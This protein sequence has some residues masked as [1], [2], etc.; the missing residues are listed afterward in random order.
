MSLMALAA[1]EDLDSVK[2]K[3]LLYKQ[4]FPKH[5]IV[6]ILFVNRQNK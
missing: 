6:S 5:K 4:H 3:A 2:K 1:V